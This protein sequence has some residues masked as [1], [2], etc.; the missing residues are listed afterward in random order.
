MRVSGQEIEAV[1]L[2]DSRSSFP[3]HLGFLWNTLVED[4]EWILR[5]VGFV[6]LRNTGLIP[7][8]GGMNLKD[9]V[10]AF[11]RFTD[12]PAVASKGAVTD[13]LA[14]A[15]K[16]GLVGIGRGTGHGNLQAKYCRQNVT[17][18]PNEDGVWI[19]PAFDPGAEKVTSTT[20]D[21][22]GVGTT[23]TTGVPIGT[24]GETSTGT[25][26]ETGTGVLPTTK[27]KI[28]HVR[29]AGAVPVENWSDLFTC[30]VNPAVRMPHK[31]L[32]IGATFEIEFEDE[33][34]VDENDSRVKAMQESARQLGLKFEAS[35]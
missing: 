29:I 7:E 35:D 10:D 33:N 21:G 5:R 27:K 8:S 17:L 30:F 28:K 12:K 14:Q 1:T 16:D 18:D 34:A 9:A 4:E 24:S 19:V 25:T 6:T 23:G 22:T 11:L 32:K 31:K 26:G 15:C 3:E 2:T 13:G 20:T